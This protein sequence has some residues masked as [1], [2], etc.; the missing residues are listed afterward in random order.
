MLLLT[1]YLIAFRKRW[2]K[3]ISGVVV[4]LLAV[5][6]WQ[7]IG[8]AKVSHIAF[9]DLRN[10]TR[11]LATLPPKPTFSD[12]QVGSWFVFSGL[13]DAGWRAQT[14]EENPDQRRQRL[15]TTT[16][17]YLVTGGAREPYYGCIH[18]IPRAADVPTDRWSLIKEFP[19][20]IPA[21]FWRP[22]PLRIWEAR[23]AADGGAPQ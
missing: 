16:S 8:T 15:T 18:C 12:F 17:G 20:P 22:E 14:I 6:L 10:T 11:F 23:P 4:L 5:S 19:D 2:P 13:S 21:T 1:G 3:A 7:S 9:G